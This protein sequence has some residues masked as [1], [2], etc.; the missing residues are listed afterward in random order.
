MNSKLHRF[1]VWQLSCGARFSASLSS[2]YYFFVLTLFKVHNSDTPFMSLYSSPLHTCIVTYNSA[3]NAA[4]KCSMSVFYCRS[5]QCSSGLHCSFN[6]THIK[7]LFVVVPSILF[8]EKLWSP[9]VW[10][11]I[12]MITGNPLRAHLH[13]NPHVQ[14]VIPHIHLKAFIMCLC[15]GYSG[16]MVQL[17]PIF[18]ALCFFLVFLWMCGKMQ[19]AVIFLNAHEST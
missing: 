2:F 12:D 15:W 18:L 10:I 16:F 13:D 6:S 9:Q 5:L 19:N 17:W 3:Q 11:G 7:Q 14:C 8:E 4:V 1:T